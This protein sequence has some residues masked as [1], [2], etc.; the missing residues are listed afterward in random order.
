MISRVA[1]HCFWMARYLERAENTARVLEVNQTLLLDFH[2]PVEQQW[3]PVLIISG[4]HDYEG[5]TGGES[6]Q[7][8]MTWDEENPF[9]IVSSLAWARENARIIREVISA[10]M[11]ERM[12][13][14]HL[15]LNS[16]AVRELYHNN[17]GEFYAQIRRI[18]QLLTGICDSTMAH[19]EAWEFL[20]LG[21]H[22]ERACQTAR[23][24]DVKYHILLPKLD[25]VGT[26]VDNAHWIAILMS[27]SGYEPFHKKPMADPSDPGSAVAEFLIFDDDFPRSIH[28]CLTECRRC[29]AD[30]AGTPNGEAH[31][32][33][34]RKISELV[35]WLDARDIK[36]VISFGLHQT[37]THV[38]DSTH[39]IGEAIQ[40]TYF[41]PEIRLPES[42]AK[43]LTQTQSQT[44]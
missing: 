19:G 36:D 32:P 16:P 18:N 34:D 8:Y 20:R 37:L 26:A 23:T 43:K 44:Q 10:E 11:W 25:D 28:H 35:H 42:P 39:T 1:E 7:G 38:V 31:T 15:W 9:S 24:L 22:L 21:R 29:L 6:V 2:V 33:A 14:Y 30:I 4:I 27:C 17:R 13:Y 41:A 3:K 12:N 40:S 5:D